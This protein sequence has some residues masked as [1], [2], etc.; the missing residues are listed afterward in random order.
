MVECPE[1]SKKYKY[2]DGPACDCGYAFVFNPK[3]DR[4]TDTFF[5]S[6]LKEV[7]VCDTRYFTV[8]QLYSWFFRERTTVP[9]SMGW[10]SLIIAVALTVPAIFI[11]WGFSITA[12]IFSILG[13]AIVHKSYKP[14]TR[15]DLEDLLSKWR[16]SGKRINK[17]IETR[18]LHHLPPEWK[19]KDIYGYGAERVLV[20]QREIVVDWLVKNN[21]HILQLTIVVAA[22]GYPDYLAPHLQKALNDNPEMPIYTLHDAGP[23]GIVL[24]NKL[25]NRRFSYGGHPTHEIC[26]TEDDVSRFEDISAVLKKE[27]TYFVPVDYISYLSLADIIYLYFHPKVE[28]VQIISPPRRSWFRRIKNWRPTISEGHYG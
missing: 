27:N 5:L 8:N 28:D 4:V 26:I 24:D 18:S 21:F 23:E 22:N 16:A 3:K 6:M 10:K 2:R 19:E 11:H 17:L 14:P 1:C 12:L 25:D 20:V 13:A 15:G 7:S 9:R